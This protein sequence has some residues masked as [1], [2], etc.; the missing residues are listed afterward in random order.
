MAFEVPDVSSYLNAMMQ[1][2]GPLMNAAATRA[3]AMPSREAQ[4]FQHYIRGKR[5]DEEQQREEILRAQD[6]RKA[7][8]RARTSARF[9][10]PNP[11]R[12]L[13]PASPNM[14][15]SSGVGRT[16]QVKSV[17]DRMPRVS[18]GGMTGTEDWRNLPAAAAMTGLTLP[19]NPWVDVYAQA[20]RTR[21]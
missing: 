16:M 17:L 3:E 4:A 12:S 1:Y 10:G 15:G 9:S 21:F 5:L 20:A 7:T 13:T 2:W 6:E 14:V 18:T 19:S 11:T 8:K